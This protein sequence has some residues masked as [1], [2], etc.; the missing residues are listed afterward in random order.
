MI[1]LPRRTWFALAAIVTAI[2]LAVFLKLHFDIP[3]GRPR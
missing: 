2:I 3:I 1:Y